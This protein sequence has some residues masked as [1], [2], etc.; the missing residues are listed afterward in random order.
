MLHKAVLLMQVTADFNST[1][2][3]TI[4]RA[5]GKGT[6]A[7]LRF[8]TAARKLQLYQVLDD[9]SETMLGPG[10]LNR[11]AGSMLQGLRAKLEDSDGHVINES[12]LKLVLRYDGDKRVSLL[13]HSHGRHEC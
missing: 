12:D 13:K 2:S 11:R 3:I 7:E 5:D 9:G 6:L 4:Q 10:I 1:A 8:H